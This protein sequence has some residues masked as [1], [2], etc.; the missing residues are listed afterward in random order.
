M[1]ANARVPYDPG[2]LGEI[3][4]RAGFS[5]QNGASVEAK[6]RDVDTVLVETLGSFV[7]I[8]GWI[9]SLLVHD[10]RFARRNKEETPRL[11]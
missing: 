8:V 5:Q 6:P 11:L 9:H 3:E 4:A 2:G 10:A 7:G 1:S